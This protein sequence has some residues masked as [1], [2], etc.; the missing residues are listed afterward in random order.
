[1]AKAMTRRGNDQLAAALAEAKEPGD[2][3]APAK[4]IALVAGLDQPIKS[5][6]D[7]EQA[8][9]L[10]EAFDQEFGFIRQSFGPQLAAIQPE[11]KARYAGL[12][13]WLMNELRGW[14]RTEDSHFR[15][16][17]AI[18]IAARVCDFG[19]ELWNLLPEDIG[20]NRDLS[21]YLK[22]LV[23]SFD[24]IF[25][26]AGIGAPPIWEAELVESFQR[27]D[28]V[29]D[30]A[31]I[32]NI[33]RRFPPMFPN[34]LQT[35]SVRFLYR[36]DRNG[37]AQ[38]LAQ[39][40][41]TAV[42]MQVAAILSAE[43][44]LRFALI[45]ENQYI[46]FAG[47]Y[48]SLVDERGSHRQ[49]GADGYALL[50]EL[51]LKVSSDTTRWTAWM[52]AFLGYSALQKPL[53]QALAQVPQAALDGYINSI[54]LHPKQVKPDPGR[55]SV[56]E[57]LRA[58]CAE[59]SPERRGALWTLAHTRWLDWDFN[60][61][62]PNQHLMGLHWSDLDYAIVAYALECMDAAGRNETMQAIRDQL[63][64]LEHHWHQSF[65]DILTAWNRLLS[66][67]QPYAHATFVADNGGDWLPETKTYLPFDPAK[68]EYLTMMY[69]A[70]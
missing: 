8:R 63:L 37:L 36:Y 21:A 25:S 41:K 13:R 55:R 38:C 30:W 31:S 62:D 50:T 7:L 53:G 46:Q 22:Q 43:Q 49:L 9:E 45:S 65:T 66:R 24:V 1:M 60:K 27:A 15:K 69:R 26:A 6:Q 20:E 34:T 3:L 23:V 54:W 56:T 11:A 67:F 59:A 64:S 16:L 57:C 47:I 19:N 44:R 42:A 12:L 5:V 39:L 51:L 35:E 40:H 29:G 4:L 32:A 18:L 14:R 2:G 68:N 17:V 10:F 61:A 28:E 33:W 52:K 48:R 58:F 70:M